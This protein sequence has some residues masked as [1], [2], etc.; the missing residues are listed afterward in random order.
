MSQPFLSVGRLQRRLSTGA[1]ESL[2][3]EP[4]VNIL[5]GR[6][7]TG[8]T[9]WLQT[10][11]YLLGDSGNNPFEGLDE[12]GLSQ[13]YDA[14]SVELIIGAQQFQ[15]ERRWTEKG[16][17]GKVWVDGEAMIASDFQH[18]LME[19]LGIPIL[20]F[21]KGN[22]LSGQTWPELSFRML[23]RHIYRQQRFWSDLV[24]QQPEGEQHACRLQ[25]LGVAQYLFSDSYGELTELKLQ[26]EK[27][28]IRREQFGDSINEVT[29]EV[30]SDETISVGVN[31][32]TTRD[33]AK[34]I[35]DEID[36]LRARRSAL[37]IE[38]RNQ[39]VPRQQS[40]R[41]EQLSQQR[42]ETLISLESL[43]HQ[44]Q[45]TKERLLEIEKYRLDL[46]SETE[47]MA[48]A[49]DAADL[50][51]DLRITHCPNCDQSVENKP[52]NVGHCFLCE[53]DL[54]EE[55]VIEGLG[56]V[57]V[58]FERDRIE[59]EIKEAEELLS[60][61]KRESEDISS[62]IFKS[63]ERRQMIENELIPTRQS[64]SALAGEEISAIDTA[65]GELNE[66]QRQ[67][68][69]ISAAL[70]RGEEITKRIADLESQIVELEAKVKEF[71][72]AVDF[73]AMAAKLEEGMNAYLNAINKYRSGV[74][75]HSEI[76]VDV[77]RYSST[78]KI[79]SKRWQE[80]GGTD[81]LYF[82]AAYQYG[83]LSLSDQ[84]KSHYPGFSIIDIPGEFS[85]EDVE[86][87]ENFIVQ[88]FIDLLSQPTFQGAQLIITGAS[89][90]GLEQVNRNVLKHVF[91]A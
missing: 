12:G 54:P 72:R 28:K 85:G 83:L 67:V 37:L 64:V 74:W 71:T 73:D 38:A 27:L 19:K 31:A 40:G 21:P 87:K 24:P 25:F 50:L 4:G 8:K 91:V 60:L 36:E 68:G 47:R 35:N 79:G 76:R 65:L 88:P 26:V 55:P 59:S 51:A 70:A 7:T 34:R 90:K 29:R 80:V 44:N 18:F 15:V 57:R 46:T 16:G 78:F 75:R 30:V 13:K 77:N 14:A 9:K 20:H 69:R 82:L 39:T 62:Q 1:F 81:T 66:R 89:F 53:Q 17:K 11:D 41:I 3:F 43:R 32:T 45:I 52:A 42:A 22:P 6:S 86:D 56:A 2:N 10:L 84:E 63:E 48:R 61:L 49:E 33:A 5:V 23:L 58:R